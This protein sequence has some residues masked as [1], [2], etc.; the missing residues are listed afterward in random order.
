MILIAQE[1]TDPYEIDF[2]KE[3]LAHIEPRKRICTLHTSYGDKHLLEKHHWSGYIGEDSL[4]EA[5]KNTGFKMAPISDTTRPPVCFNF[6]REDLQIAIHKYALIKLSQNSDI[7]W[8]VKEWERIEKIKHR[9]DHCTCTHYLPQVT[10]IY[11]KNRWNGEIYKLSKKHAK[12]I[13][14]C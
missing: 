10:L 4:V 3:V 5:A 12:A 8:A 2:C 13:G 14:L 11:F 9:A 7:A 6:T 1:N